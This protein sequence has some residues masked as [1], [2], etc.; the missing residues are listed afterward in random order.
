M[1]THTHKHNMHK[2]QQVYIAKTCIWHTACGQNLTNGNVRQ[3]LTRKSYIRQLI[4][5]LMRRTTPKFAL[6][7]R[8]SAPQLTRGFLYPPDSIPK[9]ICSAVCSC[10]WQTDTQTNRTPCLAI[11][12]Y[13]QL[14]LRC[15]LIIIITLKDGSS[16]D[17]TIDP[18]QPTELRE[19]WISL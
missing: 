19:Y 10:K 1:K 6:S 2:M 11:G 12:R 14:T 18:H 9:K 8:A 5:F 15:G 4:K 16:R 7:T 3:K 17:R 13:R